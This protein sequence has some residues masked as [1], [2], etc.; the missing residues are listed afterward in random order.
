MMTPDKAL[1]LYNGIAG[2]IAGR[3]EK[4]IYTA[5][6]YSSNLDLL[7]DFHT[8][9]LNELLEEYIPDGILADMKPAPLITNEKE[10]LETIVYYCLHG[11]GGEADIADIDLIRSSFP[12]KNGMG[13]TAVQAALALKQIG[14]RSVV[15]LSDDSEEVRVQL[16]SPC[17]RVPLPDGTLGGAMDVEN[18]N[19]QEVHAILQF[20]KGS[21]IR[22]GRQEAAIPVSNRLILTRNTVNVTLPLNENYLRWIEEH[23]RM[24]G[25]N[26][27]SSFNCILDPKILSMRLERVKEHVDVYRKKNPKGVVYFEDAHY[28][29]A[30][31]RR[32]CI[33]TLYPYVDIMSMNEEELQYTLEMFKVPVDITDVLS[34]LNG[35][36]FLREHCGVRKGV[37]VHT[38]DYA[39][40]AGD[41]AGFNIEQGLVCG[42]LMATAKAT[43]G[44]YGTDAQI[45]TILKN[46][47][48]ER[49]AGCQEIIRSQGL[50]DHVVVVPTFYLDRPKYTIGLGDSFTGGMQLC[51]NNCLQI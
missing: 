5:M 41:T 37:I 14:A 8:D 34:C 22:L 18:T 50:E 31:V 42:S 48:S 15:H 47:F 29:D 1:E 16:D 27:L 49:G 12:Y 30:S 7:L 25:S 3:N 33:E 11:I 10:L 28:H 39:L 24:V 2:V 17:I 21:V 20:Q 13:G 45:R 51:F 6:G 26:V 32:M 44:T 9:K 36:E 38:K 46:P 23:A 43:Y 19:P 35:V 4:G 40:Y